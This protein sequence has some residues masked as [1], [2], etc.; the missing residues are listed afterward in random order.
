MKKWIPVL[1]ACMLIW[2]MGAMA[3]AVP[4]EEMREIPQV[5]DVVCGFAVKEIRDIPMVGATG[6]LFEHEKTGADLLYIA[7]EDTNRVFDLTFLTRPV[8]NTGL[9]HVFEHSTLDGSEKY[10][11]KTLFFSLSNQTYNTYMNATTYSVMT[12]YPVASLSEDQLLCYADYYTDSCLHPMILEDESIFREEAWRYRMASMDD[13]LTIEGTVYSEM[14]GSTTLERQGFFNNYRVAFPGS[15]VGLDQGGDPDY[16]P[17][18]TWDALKDYHDRFYHP[19]NCMVY[20]YGAFSD[21]TAFLKLLDEAFEGYEAREFVF[22]DNDYTALTEPV[23]AE[24]AFPVE[25]NFNTDH[26]SV[27]YYDIILPGLREKP[28]DE[29]ILDTLTDLLLADAS[30]LSQALQ[31]ALP[32]CSFS[33]SID[34]SA[35]DIAVLFKGEHMNPEEAETFR[36]IIDAVLLDISQN[37]FNQ[38]M[39]DAVMTTVN[40]SQKLMTEGSN[41]GVNLI[42]QM[43]YLYAASGSPFDYL[44]YVDALSEMDAWN[45]KG[46]YRDAVK[47]YLVG[48]ERTALVTTYPQSGA[49][50]EK[51]AALA[52]RLEEVK[53]AM[54]DAE[55]QAVIDAS[56]A[57]TAEEDISAMIAS[58]QA[59]SVESLPEEIK[60]YAI[61]DTTDEHGTRHMEAVADVDGIGNVLLFLNAEALP[62]EMIH[63]FKLYSQLVTKLDTDK[64]TREELDVLVGRYLY[65]L[66]IR[67]SLTGRE[68]SFIPY[69]RSSWI[70]MDEDQASAYDLFYELLF[71]T[72]FSNAEKLLEQVKALKASLRSQINSEAYQVILYR[73]LGVFSEMYRYYS[74]ANFVEYYQ[75]LENVEAALESQPEAVTEALQTVQQFFHNR[76]GAVAAFAG[77]EKSVLEN[78]LLAEGFLSR[79][80]EEARERAEWNLPIPA[81][82]EAL[83]IDSNVQFNSIVADYATVGLPGYDGSLDAISTLVND[84]YLL[85]LLRDQY[86]VYTPLSGAIEEGGIYMVT[87]R[88]PNIDETFEVYASLGDRIRNAEVSQEQL[89]GYILSSYAGYAMNSGELNGA[90]EIFINLINGD[91]LDKNI[92]IMRE[93]KAVTPDKVRESADIYARIAEKGVRMTAG[94]MGA[95]EAHAQLYDAILNP[96]NSQDAASVELTDVPEDNAYYE[97]VRFAFEEGL[98]APLAEDQFGVEEPATV[99]DLAG[100][101]YV[102]IGGAPNAAEEAV[103]VLGQYGIIPAGSGVGDTLNNALCDQIFIGFGTAIG[104][105]LSSDVTEETADIVL[106]RGEL[107]Q[108]LKTFYDAV[109]GQ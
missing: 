82:R 31:K 30:P 74:Y 105:E 50:E 8:D 36:E 6:V 21:Y 103:S 54:S 64:H 62:Q 85:P 29:R 106:T 47:K 69:L 109:S 71:E 46:L 87:Y 73:S 93:L 39:V 28:E 68:D 72:D 63:W 91:P 23:T 19:S 43:A 57:Q 20:L 67:P 4:E 14:L 92:Q 5:G 37:G 99:G 108:E 81:Q 104:L 15:V 10:P 102:L 101:L 2:C 44:D 18:M 58:L 53:A 60:E 107:A 59:V 12:T 17:D 89:N 25:A 98:M 38:E 84:L 3:D 41:V 80:D 9:P 48:A 96:F 83:V 75:F 49:R 94:G 34:T 97:A 56:N 45:Q 32:T 77:N 7:N 24:L 16:I 52:V 35:P 22:E 61:S 90:L 42:S 26:A 1:L 88:D 86:G 27:V 55:K 70:A 33:C 51:D 66:E 13:P 76:F 78:R 40:L 100:A 65:G 79:L 95:I 11:S